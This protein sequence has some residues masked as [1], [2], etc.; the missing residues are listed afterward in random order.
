MP[1]TTAVRVSPTELDELMAVC[2]DVVGLDHD[3]DLIVATDGDGFSDE[4][5]RTWAVSELAAGA[6]RAWA[7]GPLR[8]DGWAELVAY[9]AVGGHA[10]L[11]D[12]YV[13]RA[14][15]RAE[16]LAGTA[17]RAAD[18]RLLEVA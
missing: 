11:V 15:D 8:S 1:A 16:Q 12:A 18:S 6:L 14:T 17:R 9:G 10:D 7:D 3:D 2:A 13:A 4:V 5:G